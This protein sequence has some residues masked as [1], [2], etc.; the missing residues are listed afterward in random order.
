M[1]AWVGPIARADIRW[2]GTDLFGFVLAVD[3]F[4][5]AYRPELRIVDRNQKIVGASA[6][7]TAGFGVSLGPSLA[8]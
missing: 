6:L 4:A 7:P 2:L 8:F 3:G 5:A 1:G